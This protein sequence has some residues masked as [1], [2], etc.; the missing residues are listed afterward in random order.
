MMFVVFAATSFVTPLPRCYNPTITRVP[1]PVAIQEGD[2]PLVAAVAALA[3]AGVALPDASS[4]GQ[5]H[6]SSWTAT[7]AAIPATVC[8]LLPF[9]GAFEVQEGSEALRLGL[10]AAWA[11]RWSTATSPLW[12]RVKLTAYPWVTPSV[13]ARDADKVDLTIMAK[14]RAA[15]ALAA[16]QAEEDE[17]RRAV[18]PS[19]DTFFTLDASHEPGMAC[20]EFFSEDDGQLQWVCV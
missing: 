11:P 10:A 17:L 7:A 13:A 1:T 14:A 18:L 3:V 8:I 4:L 15:M 12:Q 19:K 16:E 20:V 2:T 9:F 5:L 6:Y